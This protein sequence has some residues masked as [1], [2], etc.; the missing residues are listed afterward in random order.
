MRI[1]SGIFK[2][3]ILDYPHGHRSHPMSEK[4]R[5]AIFNAL[6]DISGLSVFDPFAGT[7]A[8]S[9]EAISRGADNALMLDSDRDAYLCISK[10]IKKCGVEK[11]CKVIRMNSSVFSDENLDAKYDL[12]VLDPPFDDIKP[13]L[14]QKLAGRHCKKGGVVVCNLPIDKIV[15]LNEGF[16]LIQNNAHGDAILY[17]YRKVS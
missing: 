1:I 15:D 2:G 10:N 4:L 5:G 8:V 11:Q 7:G 14:L 17:F 13:E 12:V 9:L 6:G 3:R 16:D